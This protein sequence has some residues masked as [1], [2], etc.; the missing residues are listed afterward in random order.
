MG[1]LRV[2]GPFQGPAR[3]TSP[4][5]PVSLS[6]SGLGD[7][8]TTAQRVT[9]YL[10]M[11]QCL[12]NLQP[13]PFPTFGQAEAS[14]CRLEGQGATPGQPA[15]PSGGW[16]HH[17]HSEEALRVGDCF[18]GFI[19]LIRSCCAVSGN[20]TDP[21]SGPRPECH[22]K[23]REVAALGR[24]RSAGRPRP[25]GAPLG[26]QGQPALCRVFNKILRLQSNRTRST[27]TL[28]SVRKNFLS[29]PEDT[30]SWLLEREEEG[31][32]ERERE[33]NIDQLLRYPPWLG[34]KPAT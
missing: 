9:P 31:E 27:K 2:P 19:V 28:T 18:C 16:R 32:T 17:P 20:L 34:A 25:G 10:S 3:G 29:L 7:A 24:W 23:C 4:G 22:P 13:T 12:S 33:R 5:V 8:V 26:T 1:M 21:S 6:L 15:S 11:T 30:F 14:G